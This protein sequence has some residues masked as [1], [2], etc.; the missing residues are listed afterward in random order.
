MKAAVYS[1]FFLQKRHLAKG[2]ATSFPS[3]FLLSHSKMHLR[4][5]YLDNRIFIKCNF[6]DT[7]QGHGD[8]PSLEVF[9]REVEIQWIPFFFIFKELPA[10]QLANTSPVISLQ[11]HPAHPH[12]RQRTHREGPF[13]SFKSRL[14]EFETSLQVQRLR[15]HLLMQEVMVQSLVEELWSH[16]ANGQETKT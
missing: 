13:P 9:R 5:L 15:L 10:E 8:C 7:F 6:K 4:T 16:K 1:C 3:H 12:E 11:L 14:A 2:N